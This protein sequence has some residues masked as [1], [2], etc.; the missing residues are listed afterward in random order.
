M[1]D[2]EP[3]VSFFSL[4]RL[5]L[6]LRKT[7]CPVKRGSDLKMARMVAVASRVELLLRCGDVLGEGVAA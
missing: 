7:A 5:V 2:C 4:L 6:G 3:I 1:R